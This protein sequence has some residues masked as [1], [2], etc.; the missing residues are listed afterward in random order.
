MFVKNYFLGGVL[1]VALNWSL[2]VRD[3]QRKMKGSVVT[4]S[5]YVETRGRNVRLFGFAGV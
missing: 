4:H 5:G 3:R 2:Q 1:F